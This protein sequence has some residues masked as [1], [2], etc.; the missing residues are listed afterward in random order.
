MHM[1]ASMDGE[2]VDILHRF[3]KLQEVAA[4]LES[5]LGELPLGRVR[6]DLALLGAELVEEIGRCT[7]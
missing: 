7:E 2:L 5:L 1:A 6:A 3:Q 4:R